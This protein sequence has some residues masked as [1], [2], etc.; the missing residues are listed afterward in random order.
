VT[1]GV[2]MSVC[3]ITVTWN[4]VEALPRQ[5]HALMQQSLP[6]AE[7]IV[8]DNASTDG[9]SE[10]LARDFPQVTVLT[11]PTNEGVGGGYACGLEYAVDKRNYSWVWTLDQDSIPATDCLETL[12]AARERLSPAIVK[13]LGILAPISVNTAN[14]QA[15]RAWQWREGVVALSSTESIDIGMADL[16]IS[17]GSLIAAEAV[18]QAGL[19]RKDFF[20]DF[21]DFEYCLRLR[22]LGFLISVVKRAVLVH[23]IGRSED[24]R[25]LGIPWSWTIHNPWREYYKVRN[26][27]YTIWYDYP[28]WRAKLYLARK[29]VRHACGVLLFDSQKIQRLAFMF[30]GLKDGIRGRLGIVVKPAI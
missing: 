21:V 14:G 13:R 18:K 30:A 26:Q 7:I 12:L 2:T 25:F 11:L 1:S 10:M 22:R 23:S 19:P 3:S 16:V 15:Y 27:T 20:M 17:S 29:F 28:T 5:L 9:T 6:I 24:K 4:A 8:V